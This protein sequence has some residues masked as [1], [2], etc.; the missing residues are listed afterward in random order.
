MNGSDHRGSQHLL[1][2]V[3]E[4]LQEVDGYV[5]VGRKED[6][7]ISG[8]EVVDLSLRLVLGRELFGGDPGRSILVL[9]NLIHIEILV[10]HLK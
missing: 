8:E 1:L 6:S 3:H 4:L 10:F 9:W 5:V 7:D 2:S